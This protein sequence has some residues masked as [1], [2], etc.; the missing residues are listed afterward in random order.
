MNA[1]DKFLA[2]ENLTD[3]AKINKWLDHINEQDPIL[4]AEVIDICKVDR[5]ARAYYVKRFTEDCNAN[6]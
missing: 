2:G 6:P 3:R 1:R 4:R 5:G